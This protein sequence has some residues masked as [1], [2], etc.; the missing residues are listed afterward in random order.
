[1]SDNT[2]SG[3]SE[4]MVRAIS[5]LRCAEED[6]EVAHREVEMLDQ[7]RW[8]ALRREEVATYERNRARDLVLMEARSNVPDVRMGVAMATGDS[9]E[10]PRG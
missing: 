7:L 4:A 8:R 2:K 6:L 10:P 5:R 3:P 9:P 1:M